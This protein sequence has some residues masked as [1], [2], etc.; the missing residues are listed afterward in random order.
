MNLRAR[1]AITVHVFALDSV[2]QNSNENSAQKFRFD[3]RNYFGEYL[4]LLGTLDRVKSAMRC[5]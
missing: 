4:Q 2:A 3:F 1:E 5:H